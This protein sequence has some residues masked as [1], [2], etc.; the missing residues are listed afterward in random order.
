[1]SQGSY[2][3]ILQFAL[4]NG[5]VGEFLNLKWQKYSDT[6]RKKRIQEYSKQEIT[7]EKALTK[8]F[9]DQKIDNEIFT[10]LENHLDNFIKTKKGQK[11]PTFDNP[12]PVDFGLDKAF[13]RFLA[14]LCIFKQPKIVVE[15]GV[16]NGFSSSYIL[17]ALN[18]TN[19]G[20]LISIDNLF[21][22]WHRKD[23]V[24]LAIPK[25]LKSQQTL[26]FGNASEKLKT[27]LN[28]EGKVDIFIHDS[29]HTYQNMMKEFHIVWPHIQKGGFLLSDDVDQ[30]D[31]FLDFADE[32]ERNPFII[33]GSDNAIY[34]GIIQK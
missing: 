18:R 10:D 13:C 31:A 15:T 5:K 27:I 32:M 26:I 22:P 4:K 34:F 9:P 21:L 19:Q 1:M 11:N 29:S 17:L 3:Q 24:G 6:W 28:K 33:K 23:K 8:L 2:F 12:Y 20:K 16:A 30:H 14:H 7:Y 25:N